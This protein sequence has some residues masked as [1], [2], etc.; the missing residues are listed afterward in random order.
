MSAFVI[1]QPTTQPQKTDSREGLFWCKTGWL[2]HAGKMNFYLKQPPFA[3]VFGLFAA[4]RTA[5]WYKIQ[6]VLML[7][8]VRFGAKWRAFCY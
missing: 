6:C 7:N 2:V 8:T 1:H 5:F 3:P 4:K